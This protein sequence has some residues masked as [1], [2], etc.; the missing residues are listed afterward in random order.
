[1][2]LAV[3]DNDGLN[4]LEYDQQGLHICYWKRYE[5]EN[6]FVTPSVLRSFSLSKYEDMTLFGGYLE[7]I[8]TVLDK[9]ILERL[10]DGDSDE[11]QT[12]AKSP[13]EVSK[14]LWGAKTERMKLSDFAEEF[15][16]R[17]AAQ[18][19]HSLLLK[20]GELHQLVQFAE[21]KEISGEVNEKLDLIAKLFL[22]N[23]PSLI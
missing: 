21:L 19:Q 6:Y 12:Y 9:L 7:Q 2:G 20:K 10:F 18:L 3:L 13:K 22:R 1:M 4:R 16:R 15:F 17:L 23:N 5:T 11:F 14:L 8:D